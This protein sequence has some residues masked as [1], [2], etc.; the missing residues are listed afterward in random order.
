MYS[1]VVGRG[2]LDHTLLSFL[3]YQLGGIDFFQVI[4]YR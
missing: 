4:I 3:P 2:L 1:S